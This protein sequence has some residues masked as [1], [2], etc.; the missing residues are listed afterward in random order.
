MEL[1][2]IIILGARGNVGTALIAELLKTPDT[3][4][5]TAV[6]RS[7]ST[8]TPP[9]GPD[10]NI[11][12][13]A[14]DYSS[15]NSLKEAFTGQDAVVNC[16]TGGATQYE[17]SKLII[18]A[19]VAA[20]VKFFFANEY[21]GNVGSEQ[22][23]RLPESAAGA[24]VRVREYLEKLA[25]EERITWTALNGGPFFDMWLMKGPAGFDIKNKQA[26]I[27]GSGNNPLYWTPLPTIAVAAAA[28]IRNPS[29]TANRGVFICPFAPGTLTQNSLLAA[30]ETVLELQFS[31]T[32]VD[33]ATINK[34]A[35]IALGRGEV[36]K[37]MRG[38]TISNQ[39]Y[40]E[41]CGNNL[42]GLTENELLGVE[43]MNV[44]EAV[45]DAIERYGTD[46]SVVESMFRV[47]PC[48]V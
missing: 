32:H 3:F 38:F 12:R 11:T 17:P 28:I 42:E 10:A 14:V 39:F 13:K 5:I 7:S 6:S 18:D 48:D 30:L 15:L 37:A 9:T 4:T 25:K 43:E 16:V 26:R 1:K 8:S 33:V 20:G 46:V 44:E 40:E 21:V 19:A 47:E 27:Y 35:K 36:G 41:D 2:N 29:A 31:V 34:N 45:R 24:K 23:K 22:F